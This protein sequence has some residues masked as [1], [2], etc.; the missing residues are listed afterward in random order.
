ML[1]IQFHYCAV[2]LLNTPLIHPGLELTT[3]SA[4]VSFKFR[5][6]DDII[7]GSSGSASM[8]LVLPCDFSL[9]L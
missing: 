3:L 2:L 1:H 4:E 6:G 9:S 5:V 7:N 8:H